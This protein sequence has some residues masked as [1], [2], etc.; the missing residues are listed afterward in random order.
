MSSNS[1]TAAFEGMIGVGLRPTHYPYLEER[2][3]L[4]VRWFEAISENYMDSQGRPMGM[5][6]LIRQD[7]PVALHGVSLSIASG[8]GIRPDYIHKLKALIDRIDP[9][10]VSDHLCWTGAHRGNLHD[11]LPIPFT[12]EALLYIVNNIDY[13][14]NELGRSILLEN[15]STYLQIKGAEYTEWDFITEVAQRSGCK[16]LLDVNNLY[17]NS[18][19]HHFNPQDYLDAIPVEKIG[20]IHL[21]GYTDMDTHLFDTHS[22]QVYPAVWDLFSKLISRAPDVPVLIEWDDEIPEFPR[23]EEEAATA[24]HYWLEQHG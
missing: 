6:E 3:P 15:V 9:W 2:P 18:Q 5:L 13:V 4:S 1:T 21:A 14:Q 20:Q 16:V 8:E 22:H 17:V 24:N 23:L 12:Q 7:Y 10:I 19:N 11:L